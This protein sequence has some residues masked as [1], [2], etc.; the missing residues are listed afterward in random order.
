MQPVKKFQEILPSNITSLLKNHYST[1][2]PSFYESQSS[3]LTGVYKTYGSIETANIMLCFSRNM[4]LE[5]IRQR[6]KDLN[7]DVSLEKFWH[8]FNSVNKPVEKISKIVNITSIPKETVRRKV[9]NLIDKNHLCF[10]KKSKG[11]SWKLSIQEKDSFFKIIN[12]EINDLSKFILKFSRIFN[13]NLDKETIERE[14]KLQFSFYWYHFLTCQVTWL[15]MWQ[16]KFKDNDLLLIALQITI[17]ALRYADTSNN[18]TNI[19]NIFQIIGKIGSKNNFSKSSVSA[20][21]ISEVTGIPR[22]TCTRK[23]HKLVKLGFLIRETKT[24]RFHINQS[25]DAR[26]R[27]IMNKENV[28]YTIEV[29]SKYFAIILNSL[30]HNK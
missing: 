10:N 15:K 6:E 27:N 9:K 25:T 2:M 22:A 16:S 7:F 26:T 30:I 28:N 17:P 14:I 4:H 19:E 12:C 29:F 21:T 8:N 23:L 1:L 3:F 13:L 5:I 11:Y 18:Y 20:T 24:K